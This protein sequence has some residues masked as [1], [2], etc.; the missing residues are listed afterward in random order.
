MP[1]HWQ[2]AF[3]KLRCDPFAIAR[4][5]GVVLIFHDFFGQGGGMWRVWSRF[6]GTKLLDIEDGWQK[7]WCQ[8]IVIKK[9]LTITLFG[10]LAKVLIFTI[11]KK[12]W[13]KQ[14][15]LH[16]PPAITPSPFLEVVFK[17]FP[18]MAGL[19]Y[20]FNHMS[21]KYYHCDMVDM[22]ILVVLD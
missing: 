8:K 14:C 1:P 3:F 18:V 20:C 12:V 17:A 22:D 5:L 7:V 11:P 6:F 19:W 13:L 21:D 10:W 16:H 4:N 9:V 2:V 15:Q